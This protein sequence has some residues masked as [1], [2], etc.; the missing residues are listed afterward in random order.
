MISPTN[1]ILTGLAVSD[2][3]VMFDY[4]PFSIHSY[5][6]LNQTYEDLYSWNWT[7]FALFHAHFS[8]VCHAIST[9]LTVL[10]AVWRYI[11]V[12]HPA[13]ARGW[14][15]QSRAHR[16]IFLTYVSV[17]VCCIPIYLSLNIIQRKHS[18]DNPEP[19][20]IPTYVVSKKYFYNTSKQ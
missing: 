6:Q 19:D 14:C 15:S 12:R 13:R 8:V 4:I 7:L 20:N 16:L 18:P 5:V 9:W 17:I 11:S 2:M 1:S 3:L 10:L